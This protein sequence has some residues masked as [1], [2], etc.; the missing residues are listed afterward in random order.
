MVADIQ[1]GAG[2]L[3]DL[4]RTPPRESDP[5]LINSTG[6]S[7]AAAVDLYVPAAAAAAP[8]PLP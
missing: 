3:V 6:A 4:Y 7:D 2:Y 8:Q 5:V 1:G